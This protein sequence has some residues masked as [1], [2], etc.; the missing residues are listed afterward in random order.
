MTQVSS[1]QIIVVGSHAPGIF[2][3]V[4]Q[5]PRAGETVI[6]WDY[7]EPVD[8]GKGS[9]QAIAAARLGARVGFVGCVGKDRIGKEGARW[10]RK[11]GVDTTWLKMIDDSPSGTGVI[12]LN[13]EG[14]P[15]MVTS[16]GA[17]Q[18]ITVDFVEEAIRQMNGAKVLLTQFEIPVE[19]AMHAARFAKELGVISIVNPA[20]AT[21]VA[22]E[23]WSECASVLVPNE[24]EAKTLLGLDQEDSISPEELI[25]RLKTRTCVDDILI[26]LGGRG[27]VGLDASGQPWTFES[28]N[29][30][31]V[32][33]SG[34]GDAFCAAL[35]VGF[36][37][38]RSI[39]EAAKWATQ[40][41]A[42]TVTK[43][44]TILSYPSL[45]EVNSFLQKTEFA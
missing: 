30:D 29:V 2:V 3:R 40:V 7:Q 17:N 36:V 21:E 42:L 15:A 5:I 8:G 20:P 19:I 24:S 6:G 11:A 26:T 25:V 35:A 34:A 33:T 16:L 22:P 38:G 13:D 39:K 18:E 4:K 37:S 43:A 32:D 10:M 44:G 31:V 1:P 12:L 14:V 9:N 23:I 41:A 45:D 28:P 27:I